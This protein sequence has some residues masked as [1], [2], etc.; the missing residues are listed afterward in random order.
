MKLL[1]LLS[2]KKKSPCPTH[3]FFPKTGLPRH[4]PLHR[5]SF[6]GDINQE[7]LK[8]VC[9]TS[10]A[11]WVARARHVKEAAGVCP[12]NMCTSEGLITKQ[13]LMLVSALE[14]VVCMVSHDKC[15]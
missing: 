13:E 3:H 4:K 1:L 5:F 11:I 2:V 6:W 15:C 12:L 8:M 9:K 7:F 14:D 10:L